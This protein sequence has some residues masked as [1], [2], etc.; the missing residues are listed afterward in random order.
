MWAIQTFL[1][2]LVNFFYLIY[3]SGNR[4]AVCLESIPEESSPTLRLSSTTS[5]SLKQIE[6]CHF[7]S[8]QKKVLSL[9][10]SMFVRHVPGI[11]YIKALKNSTQI[12]SVSL[13]KHGGGMILVQKRMG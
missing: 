6:V 10:L 7:L 3:G 8:K 13:R 11:K 12:W 2:W 4:V 9:I 5:I 1:P